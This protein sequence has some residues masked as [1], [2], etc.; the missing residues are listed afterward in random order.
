MFGIHV[1]KHGVNVHL[2]QKGKIVE[3]ALGY[4]GTVGTLKAMLAIDMGLTEEELHPLVNAWRNTNP[5]IVRFWWDVDS[6]FSLI[7]WNGQTF[8]CY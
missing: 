6:Q 1:E 8:I 5:N 2:S 4:G 3:L 7:H